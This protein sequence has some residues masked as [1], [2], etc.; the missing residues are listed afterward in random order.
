MFKVL[1]GLND[2]LVEFMGQ[3]IKSA[4][5]GTV[6]IAEAVVET[7]RAAPADAD[8]VGRYSFYGNNDATAVER[9]RYGRMDVKSADVSDSSEDGSI[10]FYAMKAGAETLVGGFGGTGTV[11]LSTNA[12]TVDTLAGKITTEALTTAAGAA[13]TLTITDDKCAAADIVLITQNGGT[14]TTGT[15]TISVVPGAGSF[16]ITLTNRHASAAFNGT[17][18]LGFQIV[19]A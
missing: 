17:F 16:V 6:E 2:R 10:E 15:P 13:A 18:I 14:N 1:S 3:L 11:T 5:N 19:K 7:A 4:P 9:I 8:V 12:G